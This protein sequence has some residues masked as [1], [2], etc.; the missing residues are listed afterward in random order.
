MSGQF[1]NLNQIIGGYEEKKPSAAT[2]KIIDDKPIEEKLEIAA[3]L[4]ANPDPEFNINDYDNV[5]PLNITRNY[6]DEIMKSPSLVDRIEKE[7]EE[8][9]KEKV[10]DV[11]Q[12]TIGG[13][14]VIGGTALLNPVG[15]EDAASPGPLDEFLGITMI[16]AGRALMWL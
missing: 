3:L 14:L 5:L 10:K 15:P 1:F 12:D 9:I 6:P 16:W 8:K 4:E 11:I 7:A 13:L 2:K